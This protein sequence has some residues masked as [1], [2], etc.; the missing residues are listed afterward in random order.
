VIGIT[1][2]NDFLLILLFASIMYRFQNIVTYLAVTVLTSFWHQKTRVH[3]LSRADRS[4]DHAQHWLHD[5]ML[6]CFDRKLA[7][8]RQTDGHSSFIAH[9]ALA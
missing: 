1:A 3:R 4:T 8:D 7:C 5:N 9:T 6:S 2:H